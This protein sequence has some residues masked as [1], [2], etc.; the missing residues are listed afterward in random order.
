MRSG[1]RKHQSAQPSSGCN[2]EQGKG[3]ALKTKKIYQIIL[4][5]VVCILCN[6]LGRVLAE[7]FGLPLWLDSFGTVCSAYVLGCICGAM[8]GTTGNL[9]CSMLFQTH[10]IYLLTSICLALLV[11]YYSRKKALETVSGTM[12][13]II[14]C[15]LIS[16][17]IS[18]PL[19]FLFFDGMTGN[20][21]G[22]GVIHLLSSWGCPS[23]LCKIIG[24]Y[25]LDFFDKMLT[26]AA[27]AV[28]IH[29]FRR[30]RRKKRHLSQEGLLTEEELLNSAP[31]FLVIAVLAGAILLPV[32]PARAASHAG[33]ADYDDYV[34]TVYSND[35]GLPCGTANDIAETTDGI[36]WIGTYAG[37][38]RYN[39]REFEWMDSYDSVRNVNCLFVDDEGRMWIGT[40]DNGLAIVINEKIV[41]VIDQTSG[42]PSDSVRCITESSDGYYYVGTTGSMQILT[43]KSGLKK[44]STLWEVNYAD[45]IS[46]DNNGNVACVTSDGRLFLMQK[47]QI[48]CS[49]QFRGEEQIN[50]CE[51]TGD[52]TLCVGSSSGHLYFYDISNGDFLQTRDLK[53]VGLGSLNNLEQ[54]DNGEFFI[55]SENGIAYLD[56]HGVYHHI[57]IS[58]FNNSIDNML[59][60]Y[61]G[62]LWFT[63]SRLGLLR[64]APSAFRD[65]YSTL[66][67][68]HQVVNAVAN[69]RNDY[70]YIGTDTGLNIIDRFL[71]N[72]VKNKLT[73]QLHGVRIRCIYADS[74]DHLWICTYGQGLWEVNPDMSLVLYD[75]DNGSF[76]NR[77]R[78]VT[79]LSDGT[80]AAA[81]DTGMS[82]IRN[83]EIL[84]TIG[85]SDGLINSMIL[86]LTEMSDGTLLAG[87][88]GDGIAVIKDGKVT[89]MLTRDD[90]LSSGVIL[91]TVPD[92][93]DDGVFIVTSNG[94]CYM[95]SSFAI[96]RL[97]NFPYYNNYDIWIKDEDTLFVTGS[98]GIY[99]VNREDLLS[100]K[101]D[102]SYDLLDSRKGLDS[103]LTANAWNYYDSNGSL[104][105]SCDT[106]VFIADINRYSEGAHAYRM[107]VSSVYLDGKS[108]YVESSSPIIV[109][110]SVKKIELYPEVINFTVQDPNVGYYLEGY[111]DQWTILPQSS[112][113][114]ITYMNLPSG[115]YTFHIAV[116]G[117][118]ESAIVEERTYQIVK[119]KGIYDSPIFMVY[120]IAIAM[121][122]FIF[123]LTLWYR[124]TIEQANLQIKMGNE[125][126][127][128]IAN[129]VDAKD[130]RTSEHS[131]RVAEYSVLIAKR[132]G[133]NKKECENLYKAA[134]MHDIGKIAIP[135]RI[136]NKPSRLTDDEYAIMKSHTSRGEEILK[137]FTLIEHV[138]DGAKYHHERYDGRGYPQGIKGEE[139]PL[140]G[141]II[142]VADAFDAMTANRIYRNQMDIG[143]VLNELK[144][145]RGTQ[146]DPHV[147]D[148]FLAILEEGTIDVN[149]LYPTQMQ[150][151]SDSNAD[152]TQ[153]KPEDQNRHD[154][155]A[156]HQQPA[157]KK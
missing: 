131:K 58:E 155:D 43:L 42:L 61:Q 140:Y 107:N 150:K 114:A 128:A 44:T 143:Y 151:Q 88:D 119:L 126:I 157:E 106:G 48:L 16:S 5:V 50:C 135:D 38:Y 144:K 45:S 79:E 1:L 121:L 103:S 92:T 31:L 153:K 25:Y 24:E 93:K 73:T 80:I 69:W 36:L 154:P 116:Y 66:G 39:G 100:G 49:M 40:N 19:N 56:S 134:R 12:G 91:R 71:R 15:S 10:W 78:L 127:M 13:L 132:M 95:D 94:L 6:C 57:N 76:G 111:D 68:E 96:R 145:G 14:L 2:A 122:F 53:C 21:W 141:R 89:H 30:I 75:S 129:T 109:E 46:A 34:Q 110:R 32:T 62:N 108:T 133:F 139:I 118:D 74:R 81:G 11:G 99:V 123:L 60:D 51:F 148:V 142:G 156:Q 152:S 138:K 112:V 104:F 65:I 105:L 83:H 29:L 136:L 90:G 102:L 37:L 9:I 120:L 82:F 7:H 72:P 113:G 115:T 101:Q 23:F 130:A 124:R 4:L 67:M 20:L 41:N 147:V 54:L 8:V 63:S 27:V 86:T 77:A 149:K 52:S 70:Y 35:N 98:A 146:F 18:I 87:T 85:Y 22:D 64:M 28:A 17:V 55:S 97:D 137:G 125:T 59:M 117:S 3:I 33:F 84:Q 47:G 26:L